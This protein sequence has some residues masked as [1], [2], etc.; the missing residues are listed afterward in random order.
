MVI[1]MTTTTPS[2]DVSQRP[3]STLK[4]RLEIKDGWYYINGQKFFVNAL[5][6][7]IGARPG[8]HPYVE[9][10][11]EPQRV[12]NDIEVIKKAG[13]N[14]IRTWSELTEEELKMVQESGLKIVF[15]IGIKP[16]EDFSDPKVVDEF[17]TIVKNVLSYSKNYDSIITYIIMNEPMRSV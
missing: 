3:G 4:T 10:F 15:G 9:R 1:L 12:K 17:M 16:D 2:A 11:S 14:A 5:G 13:F 6:Y 8:Q 7:E